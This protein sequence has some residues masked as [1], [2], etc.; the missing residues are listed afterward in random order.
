[1]GAWSFPDVDTIGH[2]LGA[3]GFEVLHVEHEQTLFTIRDRV[4]FV[5]RK[6]SIDN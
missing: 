2:L 1:M 5:A 4:S 6:P 3:N